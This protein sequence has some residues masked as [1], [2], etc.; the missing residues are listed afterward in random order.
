MARKN[1]QLFPI[2]AMGVAFILWG[3][4]T[5]FIKIGLDSIPVLSLVAIKYCFGA[6]VFVL[7]TYKTWRKLPKGIWLRIIIATSSGYVLASILFYEG[8]KLT[9]A[10]DG[11]L[12]YLT[13]PLLL[14]V[15]SIEILK[16]RFSARLLVGVIAGLVGAFLIIGE[17]I[18]NQGHGDSTN[19][20]GGLLILA[21]VITDVIGG[22]MIKPILKKVA[23]MQI[24]AVRFAIAA[25]IM[26]PFVI[27]QSPQ[28][29]TVEITTS[30][31]I[32]VGYNLIF[33]TLI[34]FSLYHWSLSKMSSEQTTPFYY[35]DPMFGAVGAMVILDERLSTLALSGIML[36]VIG[37]Y[38][39][40]VR[41][42]IFKLR[43]RR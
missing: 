41:S 12:I 4:N 37:L 30:L 2:L 17:P 18:L 22:I 29:A 7:L 8:I 38:F 43:H 19:L 26:L 36:I 34:T 40:E 5:P 23:P 9:G 28:L 25:V 6:V 11:S 14:Y 15:L 39:S 1:K 16:E 33:A 21:A 13:A 32:A 42:P 10:L 3:L 20:L 31:M 27:F 24:T 35:L